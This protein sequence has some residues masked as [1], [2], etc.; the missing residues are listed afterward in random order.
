MICKG[1][2]TVIRKLRTP[3]VEIAMLLIALAAAN[4]VLAP[5]DPGFASVTPHPSLF[6]SLLV[7]A[8]YGLGAGLCAAVACAAEYLLLVTWMTQGP[9][10]HYPTA[11]LVLLVP[12][13]VFLGMLVQRH[14]DHLRTAEAR[15]LDATA[16]TAHLETELGRMREINISLGEQIVH[17]SG[18]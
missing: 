11:P 1:S 3:L 18:T 6:V 4:L 13:T 9:L 10:L 2:K 16:R 17:A 5:D 14:I 8:R 15:A 12:T 7:L